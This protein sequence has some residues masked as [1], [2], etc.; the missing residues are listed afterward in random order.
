V[1]RRHEL[2]ILTRSIAMLTPGVAALDREQALM[3]LAELQDVE[4]RL[5]RLR[6]EL[7]R[8]AGEA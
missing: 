5:R 2:I 1:D 8:L 3:L 4:R 6:G 7:R